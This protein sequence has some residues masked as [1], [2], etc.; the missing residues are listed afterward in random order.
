M[1]EGIRGFGKI[2]KIAKIADLDEM[3]PAPKSVKK[4]RIAV[5]PRG[6]VRWGKAEDPLEKAALQG[7]PGTLPE[8]IVWAWLIKEDHSFTAQRAEMGGRQV[9][10]GAVVD[11]LVYSMAAMPVAMRVQGDYWHGPKFPKRQARDDE[12]YYR[13]T[14]QGYLVVDLWEKDIYDAV[15][16]KRLTDYIMGEVGA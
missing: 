2:T 3:P 14:E 10:G 12:Q 16:N 11:F 1:F 8:R 4:E 13:L 7:V 5:S 9:V 6:S 15:R